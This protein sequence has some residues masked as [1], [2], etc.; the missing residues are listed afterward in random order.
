M[1]KRVLTV[2][3]IIAA[4]IAAIIY[5]TGLLPG[6]G[7]EPVDAPKTV[8]VKKG[9]LRLV[10]IAAGAVTPDTTVTV[11]SKAGGEIRSFPFNEGDRLE[12]GMIV[13]RLDP[14]TEE[15]RVKQA[16]AN[17]LMSEAKFAKASVSSKDARV[18]FERGK[19]LFADGVISRQE[20]DDAEIAF[21]KAGSDVKIAE[22]EIVQSREKLKESNEFLDD[23]IIR[24]PITGTILKRFVDVGQVIS[25]TLSS[26]S[27][28]TPIFSIANLER[29]YVKASVDE[30]D[31]S[32]VFAGQEVTVTVD[33]LPGKTF[34]GKVERIAPLGKVERTVT[35]FE[36][37]VEVSDM[38]KGLLKP[39]M[40]ANAGILTGLK[41]DALLIQNESLKLKENKTGVYVMA[42]GRA[43]WTPVRTG[44]TDGL[45]TE[46]LSGVT[47]GQ[48]V[49]I[50]AV[51]ETNQDR[52]Q[53]ILT[54]FRKKR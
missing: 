6:G 10:V 52:D 47:E 46:A 34:A 27:E 4:V 13:V 37:Y 5:I 7:R 28:G 19:K 44:D 18:R 50:S 54:I 8:K 26:A 16:E 45:V 35:V 49:S 12:K 40:T 30:V 53:G 48:E 3:I 25:S 29:L 41:K 9:D 24:A 36:V 17:L 21:E 42:G 1:K 2:I 43:V 14:E 51:R 39:G 32:K 11:K 15:T 38:D 33:S 22:A 23:T 31:I 20:L